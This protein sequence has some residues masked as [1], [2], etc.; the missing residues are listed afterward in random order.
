MGGV[1]GRERK[2][3]IRWGSLGSGYR[4]DCEVCVANHCLLMISSKSLPYDMLVVC[5][6]LWAQGWSVDV[7]MKLVGL[8][9]SQG[10][11]S[12]GSQASEVGLQPRM[13]R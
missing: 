4:V 9:R 1:G 2:E 7:C 5:E 13:A 8:G 3:G 12:V 6:L 10:Q 11:L